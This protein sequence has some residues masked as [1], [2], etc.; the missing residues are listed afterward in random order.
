[1]ASEVELVSLRL[2]QAIE[3]ALNPS[4]VQQQRAEAYEVKTEPFINICFAKNAVY[5]Y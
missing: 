2:I 4:T 5:R 3:T 1:M